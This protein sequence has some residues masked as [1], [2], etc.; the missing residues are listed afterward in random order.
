MAYINIPTNETNGENITYSTHSNDNNTVALTFAF[1]L[2]WNVIQDTTNFNWK[3]KCAIWAKVESA[4]GTTGNAYN[5]NYRDIA[6]RIG[7]NYHYLA[8]SSSEP[9]LTIGAWANDK[10]DGQ[11]TVNG[12]R[13]T[14]N[15]SNYTKILEV[16][17]TKELTHTGRWATSL[18]EL[19][20]STYRGDLYSFGPDL[21]TI[22]LTFPSF[23]GLTYYTT[24]HY[25]SSMPFIKINGEW[26]P[27][28]SQYIKLN[29]EWKKAIDT[30]LWT[31]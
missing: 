18:R 22:Y 20:S 19:Q 9:A 31:P 15:P 5:I 4:T 10:T 11:I 23:S 16:E 28:Y 1:K 25:L 21:T 8:T 7:N 30:W 3:V 27:A 17:E 24:T 26:K 2:T 29:G 6:I 12:V 13:L 14:S